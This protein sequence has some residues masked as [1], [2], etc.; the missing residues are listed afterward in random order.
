MFGDTIWS[1]LANQ[2]TRQADGSNETCGP[3]FTCDNT[4]TAVE[5][6]PLTQSLHT[7]GQVGFV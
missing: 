1:V 6:T 2:C 7:N 5:P 4:V 3:S